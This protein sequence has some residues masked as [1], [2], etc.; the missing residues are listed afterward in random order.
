[1]LRDH[2]IGQ[3]LWRGSIASG[4]AALDELTLGELEA[5]VTGVA[6]PVDGGYTAQ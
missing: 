3:P 1:M 6:L 2:T 4:A 5:F